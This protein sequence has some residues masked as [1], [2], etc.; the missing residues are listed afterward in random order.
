LQARAEARKKN[1]TA[2][3]GPA[4]QALRAAIAA[5]PGQRD[6]VIKHKLRK[7]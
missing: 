4:T 2:Q 5:A 6:R 7:V 1:K 3:N